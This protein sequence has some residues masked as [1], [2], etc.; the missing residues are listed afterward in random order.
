MAPDEKSTKSTGRPLGPTGETVR[1]NI[2]RIREN[3]RIA[4]TELSAKMRELGRPIPPLGIHRIEDGQRRVDVDDLVALAVALGVSPTSLL[5]PD[6]DAAGDMVTVTGRPDSIPAGRAYRWF[7][8]RGPIKAEENW[9][10]FIWHGSPRW[11]RRQ[12]SYE[13]LAELAREVEPD[14][15]HGIPELDQMVESARLAYLADKGRQEDSNG[16]D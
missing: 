7:C 13:E 16:H 15:S 11:L 9:T 6:V 8:G 12:V 5:M 4:V 1:S 2:K 14:G 10:I 3:Q